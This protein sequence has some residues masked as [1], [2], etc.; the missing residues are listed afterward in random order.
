M[1]ATDKAVQDPCLEAETGFV[2][3]C[4]GCDGATRTIWTATAGID[5]LGTGRILCV[6]RNS[7]AR[8]VNL[9][10]HMGNNILALRYP[11]RDV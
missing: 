9:S 7:G 5:R 4:K 2:S 6:Q 10:A 3:C 8:E 11:E 1:K